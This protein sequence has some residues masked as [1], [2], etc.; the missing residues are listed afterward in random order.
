MGAFYGIGIDNA[1][2][3]LDNEEVPILDG[4]AKH[5]IKIF[6]EVGLKTSDVPIKLIKINNLTELEEGNKYISLDKIISKNEGGVI[7]ALIIF[8]RP[9]PIETII[10]NCGT[11]PIKVPKK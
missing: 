4:S 9:L 6:K 7:F 3:E 8:S 11:I 5:F 10:N 2:V 1:I